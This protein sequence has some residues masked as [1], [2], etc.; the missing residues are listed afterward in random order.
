MFSSIGRILC[1]PFALSIRVAFQ[2][3]KRR[4]LST[5]FDQ[6]FASAQQDFTKGNY[7]EALKKFTDL[8]KDP[9]HKNN[10][11]ILFELA[12]TWCEHSK[13]GRFSH[14]TDNFIFGKLENPVRS[15]IIHRTVSLKEMDLQGFLDIDQS[16]YE[17]F[18]KIRREAVSREKHEPEQQFYNGV[19]A[20][21]QSDW[22]LAKRCFKAA[23]SAIPEAWIKLGHTY[24]LL[25]K[26]NKAV[27]AYNNVDKH[28]P[29]YLE[30]LVGSGCAY[31]EQLDFKNAVHNIDAAYTLNAQV[32]ANNVLGW[33][34][35]RGPQALFSA[36]LSSPRKPILEFP[37]P[38]PFLAVIK[39]HNRSADSVNRESPLQELQFTQNLF[40]SI[41]EIKKP[42]LRTLFT[43]EILTKIVAFNAYP[44]DSY[45]TLPLGPKNAVR[46]SIGRFDLKD[47]I[48]VTFL[49]PEHGPNPP[50]LLFRGTALSFSRP[51]SYASFWNNFGPNGVS[52]AF[53]N[54]SVPEIKRWL[55]T[56]GQGKAQVMGY[57]QGGALTAMTVARFS[58]LVSQEA[59]FPSITLNPPATE[60]ETARLW[61]TSQGHPKLRQYLV[62]GDI[63]S[64]MGYEWIGDIYQIEFNN[65]GIGLN[66]HF[67]LSCA[68]PGGKCYSVDTTKDN[69]ALSR[70]VL[71]ILPSSSLGHKAFDLLTESTVAKVIKLVNVTTSS[72]F[73]ANR[74]LD[75]TK[76]LWS[77]TKSVRKTFTDPLGQIHF[78][79]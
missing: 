75:Y 3:S 45:L 65:L 8:S 29:L 57:S 30:A 50:I 61:R 44:K 63:V 19:I 31:L 1:T 4:L 23:S 79:Q 32:T 49:L 2:S 47:G 28:N 72:S 56:T 54:H 60:G 24:L 48:P 6:L 73:D 67:L 43:A 59:S 5:K 16:L 39:D 38:D 66:A 58:N 27:E 62:Q 74:L 40:N 9:A 77:L 17:L 51:G 41:Q 78:K 13:A 33:F 18:Q 22:S 14:T 46:Y 34:V 52:W 12:R 37:S 7:S 20:L 21:A 70:K 10:P 15:D 64:R 76:P 25:G 53:F 55:E 36:Q 68:Q 42:E 69:L 11:K 35:H 71:S 26:P